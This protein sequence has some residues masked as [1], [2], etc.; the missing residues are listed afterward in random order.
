MGSGEFRS[1]VSL[2]VYDYISAAEQRRDAIATLGFDSEVRARTRNERRWWVSLRSEQPTKTAALTLASL[3]LL[4]K[5]S[6]AAKVQPCASLEAFSA[7]YG[8][9][10]G[11]QPRV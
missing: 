11:P 1:L 10:T 6:N 9:I 3:G 8:S 4:S 7:E 2:G 5:G